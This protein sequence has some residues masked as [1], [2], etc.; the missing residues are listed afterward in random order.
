MLHTKKEFYSL[1]L[2]NINIGCMEGKKMRDKR[3]TFN[4]V[5]LLLFIV[6]IVSG[7][8]GCADNEQKVQYEVV[9]PDTITIDEIKQWYNDIY[10]TPFVEK[11][12]IDENNYYLL[13]SAGEVEIEGCEIVVEKVARKKDIVNVN[14][15]LDVPQK[16]EMSINKIY[17][18]LLLKIYAPGEVHINGALDMEEYEKQKKEQDNKGTN[19][20]ETNTESDD[21][22]IGEFQGFIDSNSVEILVDEKPQ[23]FRVT[24]EV[25]TYLKEKAVTMGDRLEFECDQSNMGQRITSIKSIIQ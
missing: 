6:V 11:I 13:L 15:V 2:I 4:I 20:E 8:T 17:P 22:I 10:K 7:I 25:K 18:K 1:W 14:C 12:K 23:A 19:I 21:V 16:G 24:S 3:N 9:N 5:I